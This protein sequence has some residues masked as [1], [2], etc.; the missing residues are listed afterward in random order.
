MWLSLIF[1]LLVHSQ[2]NNA[3]L[4]KTQY[5]NNGESPSLHE[6]SYVMDVIDDEATLLDIFGEVARDYLTHNL[7]PDTDPECKWIWRHMR[8]ES[9][10][11]CSLQLQWG[12]YHLGRSCR[13]QRN[14]HDDDG[15]VI[16]NNI[17]CHLPPDNVYTKML[18][19]MS[20]GIR[21]LEY[22][23]KEG[24]HKVLK[25]AEMSKFGHV[26][27]TICMSLSSK[28]ELI[29]VENGVRQEESVFVTHKKLFQ[30]MLHC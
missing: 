2:E 28:M 12:D 6:T 3:P 9:F 30:K 19:A 4:H 29:T 7:I 11:E 17:F 26:Y 21:T 1:A 27:N 18:V 22:K 13:R 10:C 8:C 25:M 16:L 24:P 20:S 23:M 15:N 14:E 5:V